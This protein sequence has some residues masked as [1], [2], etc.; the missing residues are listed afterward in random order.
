[1]SWSS[2]RGW[3]GMS[4]LSFEAHYFSKASFIAE[5]V[6]EHFKSSSWRKDDIALALQGTKIVS[7]RILQEFDERIV[8]VHHVVMPIE[9]NNSA[10]I[11]LETPVR[12]ISEWVT[13]GSNDGDVSYRISLSFQDAISLEVSHK[14]PFACLQCDHQLD[15][16]PNIF[17]EDGETYA[18]ESIFLLEEPWWEASWDGSSSS[19]PRLFDIDVCNEAVSDFVFHIAN[20]LAQSIRRGSFE[21]MVEDSDL[22]PLT[23][24][25]YFWSEL[26]E[27][28]KVL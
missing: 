27:K 13:L 22:L 4:D 21:S 12:V 16:C 3:G 20:A 25:N 10:G 28:V 1:M 11:S 14:S 7:L 2:R 5:L 23:M 15:E 24:T 9:T 26:S 8:K 19:T 6:A 18:V 17:D